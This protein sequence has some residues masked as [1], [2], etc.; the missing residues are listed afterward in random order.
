MPYPLGWAL[1]LLLAALF[2]WLGC[3]QWNRAQQKQQ[4]LDAVQAVLQQR[5]VRPLALAADS[6]R[7]HG[8]DWAAG[9]GEFVAAPAV[10]LDNQMQQGRAGVRAYRLF[11][12]EGNAAPL[13]VELGWLPLPAD[14]KLPV[15][16]RP[17]GPQSLAGLLLAPPAA[18]LA[19][20]TVARQPNGDLL[21]V[22]LAPDHLGNALQQQALASRVLRLDPANPLGYARDLDILPNTL[23]PQR[24]LAYAVQWFGLA[25]AVLVTALVLTLRRIRRAG[26]INAGS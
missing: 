22:A 11:Q 17:T 24:H 16:P 26:A 12:P 9:R 10:L 14:R 18:G 8:Y 21:L 23:P 6:G 13:L 2:A 19:A 7:R 1:A 20:A 4:Q 25:A 3:W 15:V 5:Q